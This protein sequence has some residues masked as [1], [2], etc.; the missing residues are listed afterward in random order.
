MREHNRSEL[1][2]MTCT[3]SL[4]ILCVTNMVCSEC[5]DAG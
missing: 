3:N 2:V 1:E 5:S 4:K